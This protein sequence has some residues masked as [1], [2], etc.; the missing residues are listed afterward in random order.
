[1]KFEIGEP[2]S[3]DEHTAAEG[4]YARLLK[5]R[6]WLYIVAVVAIFHSHNLFDYA[7]ISKVVAN[8][9][10]FDRHIVWSALIV[11]LAPLL[12]QYIFLTIQLMVSYKSI[13]SD[14]MIKKV[15]DKTEHLI[16]EM[17]TYDR[18][19]AAIDVVMKSEIIKLRARERD[20]DSSISASEFLENEAE[21]AILKIDSADLPVTADEQGQIPKAN[22]EVRKNLL[23]EIGALTATIESRR[24]EIK[25]AEN[26]YVKARGLLKSII[27]ETPEAK[28]IYRVPEYLMD[29]MR[30]GLPLAVSTY[31]M[32]LLV[33]DRP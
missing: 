10:R 2:F 28:R 3:H 18:T 31:A 30:V 26:G 24:A 7:A 23:S 13:I 21:V 11:A 19:I 4:A 1:M 29:A 6:R 12:I 14:R 22:D 32:L 25:T 5:A 9:V 20:V 8:T 17:K 15:S 33:N 16:A 27:Q